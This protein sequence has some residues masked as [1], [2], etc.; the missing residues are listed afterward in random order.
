MKV[1]TPR[2]LPSGTW[3]IQ[4]RLNGKSVPVSAATKKDCI[5]QAELIKAE[6]RSG[7]KVVCKTSMTLGDAMTDY[8]EK[9]RA[10]LDPSTIQGYGFDSPQLHQ[11][12]EIRQ[13][14]KL[15]DFP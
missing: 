13:P 7:K 2:K 3:F 9:K 8:I 1:P 10:S 11:K 15:L 5:R 6:H 4:L 12:R 14:L